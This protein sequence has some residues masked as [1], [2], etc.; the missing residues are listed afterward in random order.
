MAD[1]LSSGN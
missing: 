1:Q